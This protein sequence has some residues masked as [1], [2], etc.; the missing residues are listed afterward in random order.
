MQII[1]SIQNRIYEIWGEQVMLDFDL[2]A[3]HQ[4]ETKVLNHARKTEQKAVSF[5]FYVSVNHW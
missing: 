2:A 5:R 3:L 1:Q 4:V